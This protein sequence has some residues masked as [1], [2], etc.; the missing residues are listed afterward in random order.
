MKAHEA[1]IGMLFYLKVFPIFSLDVLLYFFVY[2]YLHMSNVSPEVF[3]ALRCML[4][5]TVLVKSNDLERK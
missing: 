2:V 4:L 1:Q 5:L 3:F